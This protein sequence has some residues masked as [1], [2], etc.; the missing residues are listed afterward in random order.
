MCNIENNTCKLHVSYV[1]IIAAEAADA[2][3]AMK[4]SL[5][6]L[7]RA[8]SQPQNMQLLPTTLLICKYCAFTM[9][10]SFAGESICAIKTDC[11]NA[12]AAE[13]CFAQ[14]TRSACHTMLCIS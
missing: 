10:W 13:H 8:G 4:Q 2:L 9:S 6:S 12:F 14:E 1:N 5:Q 7:H 3:N 11:C